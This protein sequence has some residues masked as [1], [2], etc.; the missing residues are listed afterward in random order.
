M[1]SCFRSCS[2]RRWGRSPARSFNEWH[3][4]Q[5]EALCDR[6]KKY[7]PS[8]WDSFPVGWGAKL[9]NVFLKTTAYVG[10]LGREGLGDALHPP[11][12]K[13]LQ[14][15]LRKHFEGRS[16][17]RTKVT[18][19][20]I[21]NIACYATYG[22]VIDGCR[23]AAQDLRCSLIEVEQ[24]AGLGLRDDESRPGVLVGKICWGANPLR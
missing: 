23:V 3:R 15:G 7:L 14:N 10:D 8:G 11:L 17:M 2:T 9:I 5:T 13:G 1:T 24:L 4:S 12:D 20:A 22:D 16:E 18:F 21:K 6:A 19:G